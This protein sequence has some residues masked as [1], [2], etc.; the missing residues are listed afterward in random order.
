MYV[1]V[2]TVCSDEVKGLVG[3]VFIKAAEND[4]CGSGNVYEDTKE[5]ANRIPRT[6]NRPP[7]E[8]FNKKIDDHQQ[9]AFC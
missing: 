1:K 8:T 4:H 6:A 7:V 9:V 2:Q 3:E 5:E